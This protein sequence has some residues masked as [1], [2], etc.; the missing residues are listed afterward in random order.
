VLKATSAAARVAATCGKVTRVTSTTVGP[1]DSSR[2]GPAVRIRFPPAVS[3]AKAGAFS[4][5]M[6]PQRLIN[7][8]GHIPSHAN[9]ARCQPCELRA[10]LSF[11]DQ[12]VPRSGSSEPGPT[13]SVGHA[14]KPMSEAHFAILRRH[15]VEVIGCRTDTARGRPDP[16]GKGA[17][18]LQGVLALR[19]VVAVVP[20]LDRVASR[21]DNEQPIFGQAARRCCSARET[22]AAG[23]SSGSVVS[24]RRVRPKAARCRNRSPTS[25]SASSH[26]RACRP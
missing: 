24:R 7:P 13:W 17:C 22:T 11:L 2:T 16:I 8:V 18:L 21:T 20:E 10:T 19:P 6:A 12:Y 15:M 3:L 9:M 1:N 25:A 5:R 26:R 23:A 14:M 4:D